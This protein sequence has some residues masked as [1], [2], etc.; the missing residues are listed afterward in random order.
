MAT[1]SCLFPLV[2]LG[3]VTMDTWHQ[4]VAVKDAFE[5]TE[6]LPPVSDR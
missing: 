5:Q 2:T 4:L 1:A 3:D 6:L